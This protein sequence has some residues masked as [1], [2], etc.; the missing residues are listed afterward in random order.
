MTEF[1]GLARDA[2]YYESRN[3]VT[4]GDLAAARVGQIGGINCI[5]ERA[6][7]YTEG[8][9]GMADIESISHLQRTAL[10]V[11]TRYGKSDIIR[12]SALELYHRGII[13]GAIL[14]SPATFLRDQLVKP[15]KVRDMVRR[16]RVTV[17]P[18]MYRVDNFALPLQVNDANLIA[19]TTQMLCLN[20]DDICEYMRQRTA[21]GLPPFIVYI[22]ESQTTSK[23]NSWGGC[24]QK[25]LDAG[26]L[27][28]LLTGTKRRSDGQEI[29]GF[30]TRPIDEREGRRY[31]PRYTDNKVVIETWKTV[32][33]DRELIAHYEYSY[34]RAWAESRPVICKINRLGI[35]VAISRDNTVIRNPERQFDHIILDERPTD[36]RIQ[37]EYS[38]RNNGKT[39]EE[40]NELRKFNTVSHAGYDN[41]ARAMLS[42]SVRSGPP[43]G[44]GCTV[45]HLDGPYTGKPEWVAAWNDLARLHP[46]W[47]GKYCLFIPK[48]TEGV[49]WIYDLDAARTQSGL[50]RKLCHDSLVIKRVVEEMCERIDHRRLTFREAAGICFCLNDTDDAE[51]ADR[52]AK[53]IRNAILEIR[54]DWNV[55]IATMNQD[56]ADAIITNFAE[57]VGDVLICKQM[58]SLGLDVER[59]KVLADLSPIR[60]LSAL[61]QRI[62]RVG[63]IA[64]NISTADYITPDD[65]LSRALYDAFIKDQGGALVSEELV[66]MIDTYERP[67]DQGGDPPTRPTVQV[68][69]T[70][71]TR[72]TDSDDNRAE[73]GGWVQRFLTRYPETS[74]SM[75]LPR[76]SQLIN[77]IVASGGDIA[78]MLPEEAAAAATAHDAGLADV[79]DISERLNELYTRIRK[80][81]GRYASIRTGAGY[82][83]DN[84]DRWVASRR[85]AYNIAKRENNVPTRTEISEIRHIPKLEAIFRTLNELNTQ[86][87]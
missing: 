23:E 82:S 22:D 39:I 66:E 28:C 46:D 5:I 79:E 19:M 80:A 60:T 45:Y 10:V 43:G 34:A 58:A 38:L 27:V 31:I 12:M 74:N 87:A 85:E 21:A 11:P 56:N 61:I 2:A 83:G 54:P 25:L 29:P 16:Y 55:V 84:K 36:D 8:R 44:R 49:E 15:A 68:L 53:Q 9:R 48:P 76:V 42:L 73:E 78:R 4:I 62:M 59:L 6:I 17:T 13:S 20:I 14:V 77:D 18:R 81:A 50:L 63:T 37:R 72:I 69:G 30:E 86:P 35:D 70:G 51:E 75:T 57:G 52:H 33:G 3:L 65:H 71:T 32:I 41:L 67:I 24:V 26:C 47:V 40:L 1:A 7:A 64:G